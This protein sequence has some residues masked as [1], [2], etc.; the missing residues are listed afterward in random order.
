M[1]F[2]LNFFG[3]ILLQ[4]QTCPLWGLLAYHINL[5][6]METLSLPESVQPSIYTIGI[7]F[8]KEQGWY[9]CIYFRAYLVIFLFVVSGISHIY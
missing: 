1:V 3:F 2:T 7:H 8:K 9:Y 5:S 4:F 6:L